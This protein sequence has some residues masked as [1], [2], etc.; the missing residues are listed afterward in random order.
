MS[1]TDQIV[2]SSKQKF[3][4][5][6]RE[7]TSD[8]IVFREVILKEQYKPICIDNVKNI[9]DAGGNVGYTAVYFAWKYPNAKIV[10]IEPDKDNY[11]VLVEN[12]KNYPNI[13]PLRA[14]LWGSSKNMVVYKDNGLGAW[15]RQTF[16]ANNVENYTPEDTVKG[17]TIGQI[18][19]AFDMET[20]DI[21]KIDIEGAE[22][23]IFLNGADFWLPKVRIMAIELHDRMVNG[24]SEALVAAINRNPY[25]SVSQH[26]EDIILR[27]KNLN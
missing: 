13:I 10:T 19:N 17:I 18:M 7:N 25:F 8:P 3:N 12:I 24:C 6:I 9:I 21:L 1:I 22:K 27:N 20:I 26:S 2:D 11:E 23:D 15:G 14:A 5:I 16:E 4:F